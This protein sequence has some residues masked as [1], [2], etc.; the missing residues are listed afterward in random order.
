VRP[1]LLL[2]LAIPLACA[3]LFARLGIW[4]LDRLAQRRAF[5]ATLAQRLAAPPV[6]VARLPTDTG[7]GH[8]RRISADGALLYDRQVVYAGR[9]HQGSPG[10]NIL[11][12]MRLASG[13]IVMV[14][15]GWAYSPDAGSVDLAKWNERDSAAVNGFAETWAPEPPA[16]TA[17]PDPRKI[18]SLR[19][20][21]AESVV[22][23][24]VLPYILV[25]TSDSVQRTDSAP[26]R[27]TVPT[28]DEGPHLNYALQWFAFATIAV[29]GGIALFLRS[30]PG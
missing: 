23:E 3:A 27:L 25:Q 7:A 4:Q 16:G 6:S 5:N 15:R 22:G 2:G 14:N 26:A 10:V 17:K 18:H 24:P 29:V 19:R 11:T 28:L 21:A 8:Y 13:A 9:S 20:S 12:P 30:R 1:R